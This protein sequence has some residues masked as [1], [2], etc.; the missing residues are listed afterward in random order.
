MKEDVVEQARSL[1]NAV[2]GIRNR[3]GEEV[4]IFAVLFKRT[5][6][7]LA[8]SEP[9]IIGD[10]ESEDQFSYKVRHISKETGVDYVAFA[11]EAW[12]VLVQTEEELE[13]MSAPSEHPD[14]QEMVQFVLE[15]K[16]ESIHW[17]AP[18]MYGV[19]QAP[20]EMENGFGEG[21]FAGFLRD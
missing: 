19:V 17:I 2:I 20:V 18:I 12:M 5:P 21:R 1:L 8:R 4:P 11:S 13:S 6:A 14:R 16:T 15:S 10:R 3:T 9:I 7:G